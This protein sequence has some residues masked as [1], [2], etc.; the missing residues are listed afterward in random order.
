MCN[1]VRV[2]GGRFFI[3]DIVKVEKAELNVFVVTLDKAELEQ[4]R[5][6][7]QE[8]TCPIQDVLLDMFT[9]GFSDYFLDDD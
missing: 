8:L 5:I 1:S 4:V 2:D 9:C 7:S 6:K 3:G